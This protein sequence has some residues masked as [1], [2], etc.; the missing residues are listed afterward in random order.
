M[1]TRAK[2]YLRTLFGGMLLLCGLVARGEAAPIP[3]VQPGVH[4]GFVQPEPIRYRGRRYVRRSGVPAAALGVLALGTAAAIASSRRH[5]YDCGYYDNCGYYGGGYYGRRAYGRGI[6]G[7]H[8]YGGPAY[9]RGHGY[10]GRGFHGGGYGGG[11]R[12]GAGVG[13][14]GRNFYDGKR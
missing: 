2:P 7:G 5:R 8:G 3:V 9:Y 4:A 11:F 10:G 1:Q 14:G 12:G 6:Y 13:P